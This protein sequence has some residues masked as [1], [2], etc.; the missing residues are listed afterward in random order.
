M[1]A[2]FQA[3]RCRRTGVGPRTDQVRRTG[4]ISEM[5]D[6]SKKTIQADAA[7]ALFCSAATGGPPS[8]GW[9]LR[10]VPWL[11]VGGVARSSPGVPAAAATPMGWTALLR[12]AP[13]RPRR[14]DP[15]STR[16]SRTHG[17]ARPAGVPARS[18]P[19]HCRGSWDGARWVRG[20]VMP[21]PLS[22]P[23]GVPAAGALAR[24]VQL[25][26]DLGLGAALGEQLGGA[27]SAGLTLGPLAGPSLSC[28]LL[29]AVGR[30]GAHAS[31]QPTPR[32]PKMKGSIIRRLQ[33]ES[34][35]GA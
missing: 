7:R 1:E 34:C 12:S 30:H 5:P 33:F 10:R 8:A 27:F 25:P 20:S 35:R 22:L 4:G 3:I 31:T 16:R 17:R 6:S 21:E 2:R 26:G 11:G 32:H 24:D 28:L 19:G 29:A 13:G 14:C 23:A 15:G 18:L 9:S